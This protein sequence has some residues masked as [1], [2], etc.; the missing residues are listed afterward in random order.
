MRPQASLKKGLLG[1]GYTCARVR[2]IKKYFLRAIIMCAVFNG[3]YEIIIR[4]HCLQTS[5]FTSLFHIRYSLFKAITSHLGIPSS[6]FIIQG[7]HFSLG[8]S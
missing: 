2:Q 5:L 6:L 8:H 7:H 1:V 3:R 4:E